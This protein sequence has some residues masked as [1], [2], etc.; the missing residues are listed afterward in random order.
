MTGRVFAGKRA[1]TQSHRRPSKSRESFTPTSFNY[2]SCYDS[3]YRTCRSTLES[4]STCYTHISSRCTVLI[5]TLVHCDIFHR[6]ND[7]VQCS[8]LWPSM[9]AS[10]DIHPFLANVH[11]LECPSLVRIKVIER[12]PLLDIHHLPSLTRL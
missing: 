8:N 9:A 11:G 6:R 5:A 10:S 3:S 12:S 1:L 2:S 4:G 7:G